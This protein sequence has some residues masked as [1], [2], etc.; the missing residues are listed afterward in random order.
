MMIK[1]VSFGYAAILVSAMAVAC[2]PPA[3]KPSADGM[4]AMS[5]RAPITVEE[6]NAAQQDWCDA[7]LSISKA[8]TEGADYA[9][10]AVSVLETN[11]NYPVGRVLFKPTLTFGNQ[12]FRLDKEGAAAYF[13]GGNPSFPNDDG[14]ALKGWTGCAFDNG[15][16]NDG[17][18]IDGDFAFTMGNVMLTN[19]TGDVTTVD[20]FW[21]FKRDDAGKLRI[22]VHKSSLSNA[23]PAGME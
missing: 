19:A 7:L 17:V 18:L 9:S 3:E 2:S 4:P 8:H 12:T 23:V 20:K 1:P 10:I 22:I 5:A 15:A 6:V 14:F 16:S 21:A 11:Y 13:I